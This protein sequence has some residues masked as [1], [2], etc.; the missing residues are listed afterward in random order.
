VLFDFILFFGGVK[1]QHP[2]FCAGGIFFSCYGGTFAHFI[3]SIT[4]TTPAPPPT[5][6]TTTATTTNMNVHQNTTQEPTP[7]TNTLPT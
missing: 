2:D 5:T 6:T 3:S 7:R 1:S 4:T